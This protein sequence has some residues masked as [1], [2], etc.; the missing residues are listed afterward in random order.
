MDGISA[1][2]G[3]I[4]AYGSGG[5]VLNNEIVRYNKNGAYK[6]SGWGTKMK[7][8]QSYW[9]NNLVKNARNS[10]LSKLKGFKPKI[11]GGAFIVADVALSGEV[12]PSTY[13]NGFMLG[14]SGTGV[15]TVVGGA[16]FLIDNGVGAYNYFNGREFQTVSDIIDGSDWGKNNTIEM[17]E[18]VY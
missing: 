2:E 18:G 7:N 10:H 6:L 9:N 4:S 5:Y 8:G 12:K 15:G 3:G 1:L 16:W 17:Y 13:I 11:A 14:I